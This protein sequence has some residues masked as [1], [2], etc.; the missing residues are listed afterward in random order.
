MEIKDTHWFIKNRKAQFDC[1]K[2]I[3]SEGNVIVCPAPVK[4]GKREIVIC[5]SL[6]KDKK[7]K[8]YYAVNLLRIDTKEQVEELNAYGISTYVGRDLR[9]KLENIK[10]DIEE[11]MK[12]GITIYLHVDELDYGS[13]VK[14]C[15]ADFLRFTM[16][17][18]V[19]HIFYSATA[20][21]MLY[22]QGIKFRVCNFKPEASYRGTEYFLNNGLVHQ[23]EEAFF[24]YNN[25]GILELS[26]QGE[27]CCRLINVKEGKNIGVVRITT[28]ED[29][30]SVYQ[31]VKANC[32]QAKSSVKRSLDKI[33]GKDNYVIKFTDKDSSLFWGDREKNSSSRTAW[34]DLPFNKPVLHIINQTSSRSTEWA[35]QQHLAF[36]HSYRK[37]S[38][39]TTILQYD[40]RCFGYRDTTCHIYTS[41]VE[42]FAIP[43]MDEEYFFELM[44]RKGWK[45]SSRVRSIGGIGESGRAKPGSY[46]VHFL[47]EGITPESDLQIYEFDDPIH[48]PG[49]KKD[50]NPSIRYKG[51]FYGWCNK[52]S[53]WGSKETTSRSDLAG[54][55]ARGSMALSQKNTLTFA[56]ID[57]PSGER[58][59]WSDSF[60]RL[61]SIDERIPLTLYKGKRVFAVFVLKKQS[62]ILTK[63]NSIYAKLGSQSID[64]FTE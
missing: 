57:K 36:Y 53:N 18:P 45:I 8:H 61:C 59:D 17:L 9:S 34:Y 37:E 40:T 20:F 64:L 16:K 22:A 39:I 13:G 21:E 7:S 49:S 14:Q 56:M 25:K 30:Q 44:F 15:F 23:A 19:V 29:K 32:G 47:F 11:A 63:D 58:E 62:D 6:L 43:A 54:F 12:N 52:V 28:M 1:A 2:D 4:S 24:Y 35:I 33:F 41:D 27:E 31:N 3:T 48:K 10:R 5:G 26:P 38:S 60:K 50:N 51:H 42:I 46:D 55:L